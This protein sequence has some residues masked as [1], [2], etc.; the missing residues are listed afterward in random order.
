M[1]MR[2]RALLSLVVGRDQKDASDADLARSLIAGEGWAIGETWHRFAP[3][4][5]TTAERAVGSKT[6]AEDLAQEVFYRVFRAA[7]SLRE[8]DSLRSFIYS[9]AV[10]TLRSHFRRR[11]VRAWLSL[12]RPETLV[13]P[14]HSTLDV[15]SRELLRK[16]YVLLD[17]L[18]P[19]DRIVFM[20][21]RVEGM[22]VEEIATVMHLSVST[23]KRSM[24]HASSRLSRWIDNDR[25]LAELLDGRFT[26]T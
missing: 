12:S 24:Q 2:S 9:I 26:V 14:G 3:M 4:V 20:L 21:R 18:S 13:E 17:R 22:T 7:P 23:V 8:T 16:F 25:S 10:R 6:E 5:L 19:R 15:E 11:Q 1:S